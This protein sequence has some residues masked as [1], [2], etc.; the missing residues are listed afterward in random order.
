MQK[1]TFITIDLL[2]RRLYDTGWRWQLVSYGDAWMAMISRNAQGGAGRASTPEE[3]FMRA[4]RQ[5]YCRAEHSDD[6][7]S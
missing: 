1:T 5:A 6:R 2:L 4:V 7:D 3:A